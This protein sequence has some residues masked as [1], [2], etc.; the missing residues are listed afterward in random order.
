MVSLKW[1]WLIIG[2]LDLDELVLSLLSLVVVSNNGVVVTF[3]G[4]SIGLLEIDVVFGVINELWL[5]MFKSDKW[6]SYKSNRI[7]CGCDQCFFYISW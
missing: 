4:V 3:V 2:P 7:S 1:L 5:W 6:I